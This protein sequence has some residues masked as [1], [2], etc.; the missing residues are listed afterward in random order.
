M[1]VFVRVCISYLS[2]KRVGVCEGLHFLMLFD[3]SEVLGAVPEVNAFKWSKQIDKLQG[4]VKKLLKKTQTS[5]N[6]QSFPDMKELKARLEKEIKNQVKIGGRAIS[7]AVKHWCVRIMHEMEIEEPGRVWVQN[8][9]LP[10]SVSRSWVRHFMRHTLAMRYGKPRNKRRML[11]ERQ[12]EVMG[13]Y[14]DKLR[15]RVSE[16]EFDFFTVPAE[17]TSTRWGS[18]SPSWRFTRDQVPLPFDMS[19]GRART[20]VQ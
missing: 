2:K 4:L 7:S 20:C 5:V 19:G 6:S 10:L 3:L 1:L 13:R 16:T 11:P 18:F 14:L 9:K 17:H 12:K 15:Y 8:G